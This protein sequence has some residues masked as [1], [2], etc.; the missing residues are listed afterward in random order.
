MTSSM[1]VVP[2]PSINNSMINLTYDNR[3]N[4][5]MLNQGMNP[6]NSQPYHPPT[7]INGRPRPVRS[8]FLNTSSVHSQSVNELTR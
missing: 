5:N 3:L 8:N 4:A 6:D 1:E 7:A 2:S